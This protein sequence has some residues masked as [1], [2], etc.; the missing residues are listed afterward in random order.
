MKKQEN[1]S[2]LA[3]VR[4]EKGTN[5]L[6]RRD[7][8][9][10]P[11]FTIMFQVDGAISSIDVDDKGVMERKNVSGGTL[12]PK[13]ISRYYEDVF[14]DIKAILTKKMGAD[15]SKWTSEKDVQLNYRLFGTV[16]TVPMQHTDKNND[17]WPTIRIF[18]F[19]GENSISK[20][21]QE[22]A[23]QRSLLTTQGCTF[24]DPQVDNLP[25]STDDGSI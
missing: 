10:K 8:N 21:I 7:K 2:F 13:N 9:N 20:L 25:A 12:P 16:Y 6:I 11:Y 14:E 19:D 24:S 23:S 5:K 3:V 1:Q 4:P 22:T 17:T 15:Q 18:L